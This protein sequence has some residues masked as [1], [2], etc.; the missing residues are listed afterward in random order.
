MASI[1]PM[2][3]HMT[4][5]IFSGGSLQGTIRQRFRKAFD[6]AVSQC[7]KYG[8]ITGGGVDFKETQKGKA[9]N[10]GKEGA[11][12]FFKNRIF[13]GM[14]LVLVR[15]RTLKSKKASPEDKPETLDAHIL[16]NQGF[17]KEAPHSGEP[18]YA[19]SKK[20]VKK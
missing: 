19:H 6:I 9:R 3:R 10:H 11:G 18:L 13:D 16:G 1:P 12:G 17:P 14:F 15:E 2:L 8:Y 7:Q 20:P 5:A 4:L